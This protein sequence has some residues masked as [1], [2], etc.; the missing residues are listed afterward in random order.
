[1]GKLF[2]SLRVHSTGNCSYS[3]VFGNAKRILDGGLQMVHWKVVLTQKVLERK[4]W[5]GGWGGGGAV[6]FT[7]FWKERHLWS[8]R[9]S[10]GSQC[11]SWRM[12]VM[13]SCT[14]LCMWG[15][16]LVN[17]QGLV[18]WLMKVTTTI[19]YA[20]SSIGTKNHSLFTAFLNVTDVS[21]FHEQLLKLK[22][23]S[24]NL[25][26]SFYMM[27]FCLFPLCII[28]YNFSFLQAA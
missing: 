2:H 11:S 20:C 6:P 12:G 7:Q 24:I 21:V 1:M 14:L 27:E 4:W 19:L 3:N 8:I 26:T 13:W 15:C 28:L 16:G 5:V 18:A 10:K 9:V 17:A 23:S 22:Y 25:R